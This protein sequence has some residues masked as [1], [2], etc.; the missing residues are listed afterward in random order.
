VVVEEEGPES[1]HTK[2]IDGGSS[3]RVAVSADGS[4]FE[5]MFLDTLNS[6]SP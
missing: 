6:Q 4:R 2:S 3:V 5:Q 1:G